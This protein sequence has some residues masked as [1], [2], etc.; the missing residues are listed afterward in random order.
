MKIFDGLDVGFINICKIEPLFNLFF[1]SN[2]YQEYTSFHKLESGREYYI[3]SCNGYKFKKYKGIFDDYR[4]S[5]T[6]GD[7]FA[8]ARFYHNSLSYYCTDDDEFYD[9]KKIRENS[10]RAIKTMEQRS[11][12]M[13]LKRIVNEEFEWS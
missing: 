1:Y 8:V 2:M 10:Q 13:I 6:G 9:V 5:R 7:R 3:L 12:N 4:Y 11:L